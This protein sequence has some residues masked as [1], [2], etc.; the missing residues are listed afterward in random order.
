M[1]KYN[2]LQ[3]IKQYIHQL[4]MQRAD[5]QQCPAPTQDIKLNLEHR[6]NAIDTA[7]YGPLDPNLPNEEYWTA[8]AKMFN[9][10]VDAAKQARCGG[11]AFFNIKQSMLDCIASGI[12]FE[13]GTDPYDVIEAG[14]LGYCEAFDFKCS[15]QRTCDIWLVGGPVKD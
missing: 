8:K 2:I 14:Q 13:A 15:A 12:G 6:Q 1:N 4:R 9:D 7:N 11:C 3:R 5:E 10:N